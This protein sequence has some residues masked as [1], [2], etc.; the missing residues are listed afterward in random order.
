MTS[1]WRADHRPVASSPLRDGARHEVVVVGAGITGLFTA[2][3]LAQDGRD[4]AVID[5]GDVAA[6]ATGANT[7]KVSLLQGSRL[8][9]IRAHHPASLVHAYVD[10][11]RDGQEL[12]REFA[13]TAG[14][15]FVRRTAFSYAHTDAGMGRVR[16]EFTA[17]REAGLDVRM[18][19]A[20]ER[21]AVPFPV[22]GAIALDDQIALDPDTLATALAETFLAAGGTLHTRTR[23]TRTAVLPSP[24]V[25]TAA[26]SVFADHIVLATGTPIADRGLYFAKLSAQR[27]YV[28]SFEVP[29]GEVPGGM[30]LSV[31]APSRS[32]RPVSA[33]DGAV[34]TTR[35]VVG[36]NGHPVGR[37]ES[38]RA[39]YEDLV[40][41]TQSYYPGARESFRWSAQD[42]ESHNLV[43][44]IGTMPRGGGRI[45]FATGYAKWGLTNGPAAALRIAAEIQGVAVADLPTWAR[46]LGTRMTAPSDLARGATENA[47]VGVAAAQGW[48]DALTHPAPV[49]KPADGEGTVG[50]RAGRPIGVST[51]GGRTRAVSAVCPHLGGV[52]RW[53]DGECTWDCPLH[54]SRFAPDGTRLE[55]PAVSDLAVLAEAPSAD[56]PPSE[57]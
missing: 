45:R 16:D 36:G 33:D 26:G 46:A 29:T 51:V 20:A 21:D 25:V 54:A 9:S 30:F 2:M 35:L 22:A 38:E 41:W 15:P 49:P 37:A 23:V 48:G 24:H 43:P 5:A 31:D 28:V 55:G 47:K 42:Y 11:N 19:R 53:N 12:V 32:V 40:A 14:V 4:V 7:G 6:L 17:A 50:S 56:S 3:L 52:L 39:Q 10:A 8:S 13:E 27:S 57:G 44:F 18:A 1:L 34:G